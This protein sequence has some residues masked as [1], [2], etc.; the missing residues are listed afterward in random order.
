M[1]MP[2]MHTLTGAYA[3]DAL[4][5]VERAQFQRH[6]AECASCAQEVLELQMTATRLGAALAE[7]P[8]PE[9]KRRVLAEAMATRQQPPMTRFGAGERVKDRRR[10]PR[11]AIA[12]VAAAVVGLAGTAVFGGIAYDSHSRLTAVREQASQYAERYAPVADVLSAADLRTG[13]AETS[14]GGGGT[15]MMSRAKDRLVFMAARLPKNEPGRIYQ[16]WLMYPGT[17][18]K[19]AGLIPGGQDGALLVAEGIGGAEKFALSVEQEGGS[20]TGTPS[21]DVV[22]VMSMPT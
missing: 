13:H 18:P 19:P 12:A 22:M 16:A 11:W 3:V 9:L 10:A 20:P 14:A 8:P 17:A 5:D 1:T 4:S 21:K 7:D 2:E 15:V 6:L